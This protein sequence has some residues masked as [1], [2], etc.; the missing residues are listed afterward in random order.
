MKYLLAAP[1]YGLFGYLVA[2]SAL[3]RTGCDVLAALLFGLTV[4]L[5]HWGF[6]LR[7]RMDEKGAPR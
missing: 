6:D 4:A 7:R 3:E 2:Q 1:L 5:M